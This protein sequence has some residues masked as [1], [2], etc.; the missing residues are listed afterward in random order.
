MMRDDFRAHAVTAA[1]ALLFAHAAAGHSSSESVA[2]GIY[3][4]GFSA[5]AGES[6]VL[7][8]RTIVPPEQAVANDRS[9]SEVVLVLRKDS[10]EILADPS[11]LPRIRVPRSGSQFVR[12][13][14]VACETDGDRCTLKVEG[15]DGTLYEYPNARKRNFGRVI[16][17]S[18]I[19]CAANPCAPGILRT[20]TVVGPDGSTRAIDDSDHVSKLFLIDPADGSVDSP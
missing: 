20:A 7:E 11:I 6:V 3:Y 1:L 2:P 17:I 4:D 5:E 13:S 15:P 14:A 19:A 9:F 8:L 12:L 16:V 18:S 10:G